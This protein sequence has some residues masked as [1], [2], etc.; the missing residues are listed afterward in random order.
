[1]KLG[2]SIGFKRSRLLSGFLQTSPTHVT[3][4]VFVT[5]LVTVRERLNVWFTWLTKCF[6]N[7]FFYMSSVLISIL[8]RIFSSLFPIYS[9]SFSVVVVVECTNL[10]VEF[11]SIYLDAKLVVEVQVEMNVLWI[12]RRNCRKKQKVYLH[13]GDMIIHVEK[14]GYKSTTTIFRWFSYIFIELK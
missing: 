8:N 4:T 6:I 9:R 12:G 13:F 14:A 11:K 3:F 7:V 1:M 5:P 2:A 10:S